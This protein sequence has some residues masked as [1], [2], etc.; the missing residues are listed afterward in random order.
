MK[1]IVQ[2]LRVYIARSDIS[3][4][5]R[6]VIDPAKLE[7]IDIRALRRLDADR[8][9]VRRVLYAASILEVSKHKYKDKLPSEISVSQ[10][11]SEISKEGFK[12]GVKILEALE[13]AE[14]DEQ[15]NILKL[16]RPKEAI[17]KFLE[18]SSKLER[19][20]GLRVLATIR[21]ELSRKE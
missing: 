4:T 17:E 10:I 1:P 12:K 11:A 21:R 13:I 2:M 14:Y 20:Y 6:D 5:C 16:K 19:M 15:E 18:C 7:N 3:E 8:E 9:I